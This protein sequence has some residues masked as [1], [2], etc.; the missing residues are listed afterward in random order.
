[1]QRA[2]AWHM[3]RKHPRRAREGVICH[4]MAN[5]PLGVR[6]GGAFA[7]WWQ[8]GI[9]GVGYLP[10]AANCLVRVRVLIC[11]CSV[12]RQHNF[13][14]TKD[15]KRLYVMQI[16]LLNEHTRRMCLLLFMIIY[17]NDV[18]SM[19]SLLSKFAGSTGVLDPGNKRLPLDASSSVSRL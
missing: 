3:S 15:T 4:G 8:M 1:M 17:L 13:N 14:K 5:G 9:F 10:C 7:I 12:A 6:Q 19:F 16:V 11:L 18:H 2:T